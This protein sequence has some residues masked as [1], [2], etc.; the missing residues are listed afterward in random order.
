M[1][2]INVDDFFDEPP[3]IQYDTDAFEYVKKLILENPEI[4]LT[5]PM[6]NNIL[7]HPDI[8]PSVVAFQNHYN[9]THTNKEIFVVEDWI[10]DFISAM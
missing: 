4:L 10:I 8:K 2:T 3:H 6:P 1:T 9:A 7:L 5:I